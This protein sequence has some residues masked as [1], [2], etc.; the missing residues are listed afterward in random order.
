MSGRLQL[1]CLLP[2][3]CSSGWVEGTRLEESLTPTSL[4]CSSPQ[5]IQA[6]LSGVTLRDE[7]WYY[8]T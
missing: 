1:G 7:T 3:S 2:E 6:W 8:L 4:H 5:G